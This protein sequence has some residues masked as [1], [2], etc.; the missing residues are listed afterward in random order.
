[1]IDLLSEIR[2]TQSM[3]NNE[4]FDRTT[5]SLEAI[6][7]ALGVGPSVG[8]WMFGAV[9]TTQVASTTTIITN[10]LQD[11]PSDL[12]EGQFWMQV[13]LNSDVPGTAPEGE[14]RQIIDFTQG[15]A[16]QTF[17]TDAFSANIEAGDL[18]CIFH[19]SLLSHH[20]LAS[21]TL[22]TSS[23]T[24]PADS[25]R[26]EG[27]NYFR[28]CLFMTTEGAER[29]SPRT[30]VEYTGAGGIFTLDPNNPLIAVPG[31]VDYV[32]IGGQAAFVPAADAAINRTPSDVVGNKTDTAVIVVDN[33]SSIMRYIKGL[34]NSVANIFAL[35]RAML[36]LTETGGTVTLTAPATED[37]VYVND[38]PAGVFKPLLVTVDLSDLAL[39]EIATIRTY[40]RITA[41]GTARLK[42]A[43]VI[44]NGVQAEPMKDIELQPNRFGLEVTIDGTTGV[45]VDWEVFYNA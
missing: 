40:Y 27:N 13:L 24:V 25:T 20:I 21:G 23:A 1:M 17:T 31:F 30:I 4:T 28:G 10:N 5:D 37:T 38:A 32:I 15:G 22:D 42:G 36:V 33:V 9:D 6:A 16:L 26:T 29:F 35:I 45:V 19:E 2:R 39:G 34:V 18:L 8:L 43:P 7:N 11:I 3:D 41:G 44:F 14:I 12:L